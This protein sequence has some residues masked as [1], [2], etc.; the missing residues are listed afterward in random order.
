MTKSIYHIGYV[1]DV[2]SSGHSTSPLETS[3]GTRCEKSI[4][5]DVKCH[6]CSSACYSIYRFSFQWKK[7]EG[8]P[9]FHMNNLFVNYI[10]AV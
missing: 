4:F 8:A 7:G 6:F 5:T 1:P 9:L 10:E 3:A 2:K